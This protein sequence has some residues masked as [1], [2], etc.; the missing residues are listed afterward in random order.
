MH[1]R[2]MWTG[3]G[4]EELSWSVWVKEF[5]EEVSE[6]IDNINICF[7]YV[8]STWLFQLQVAQAYL[9]QIGFN[10]RNFYWLM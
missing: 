2:E 10:N 5:T 9:A 1:T 6:P 8:H 3:F 7:E 4:G